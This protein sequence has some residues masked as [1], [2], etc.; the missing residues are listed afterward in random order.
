M[1]DERV[2]FLPRKELLTFEEMER[3]LSVLTE[4][5]VSKVRLTGGEPFVRNGIVEF[6]ERIHQIEGLDQISIT[7]NGTL[8]AASVPRFSEWGIHSVNL[9]MDSL[10]KDRFARITRRDELDKVL[11]TLKLL[12]EHGIETKVNTVVMDGQ[13]TEDII[14]LARLT[15]D[16][17]VTMRYIEEMPFNGKGEHPGKLIWNHERILH[18]LKREWP[19]LEKVSD[20]EF[21]TAAH[22]QVPGYQGRIGIIAAFSRTFCGTCNRLR[23]TPQGRLKTC[24][25]DGEGLDI[26]DLMRSGASDEDLAAVFL[27]RIDNRAKDGFAAEARRADGPAFESMTTIG[28]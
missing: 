26:R 23:I 17:P 11:T 24:L 8:T 27:K 10:D 19:D 6:I 14:P 20:P 13:N 7:T 16:A 1:R 9:S 12:L 3:L 2:T 25:Y 28:G 22:Y 15:K 21:S 18:E 5:G 4:L